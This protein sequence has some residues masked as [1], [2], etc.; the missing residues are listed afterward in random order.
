VP[1]ELDETFTALPYRR[2]GDV[3][4]LRAAELGAT[5]ADVRFERVRYQRIGVRD[6]HLQGAADTEDLGFAVRVIHGGAWG[7]SAGVVLTE[8]EAIRLADTAVAVAKV[9]AE[10]T[11]T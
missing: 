8:D 4:L 7:F 1:P 11:S 2:L 6:G 5:H 9:A 3:A 10:M